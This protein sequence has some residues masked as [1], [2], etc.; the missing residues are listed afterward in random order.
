M[1]NE[2]LYKKALMSILETLED[3]A[4]SDEARACYIIQGIVNMVKILVCDESENDSDKTMT[5][6]EFSASSRAKL[7]DAIEEYNKKNPDDKIYECLT[8]NGTHLY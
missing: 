5:E 4:P 3:V 2:E 8:E 6:N 1:R 7:V